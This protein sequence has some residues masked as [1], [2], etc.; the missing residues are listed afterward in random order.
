MKKI[1]LSAFISSIT[2]SSF[3]QN[4][5]GIGTTTPA[6]SALLDISS[7]NKGLLIPRMTTAQR[8]AIAT[9]A[10]GLMVFDNDT[11]SYWYFNGSAWSNLASSA[12]F[13]L[14]YQQ[15]INSSAG[16]F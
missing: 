7:T 11:S 4:N 10:K 9:P 5:I 14:P 2:A 12:A 15:S 16:A 3:A 8:T 13:T 1:I 6:S